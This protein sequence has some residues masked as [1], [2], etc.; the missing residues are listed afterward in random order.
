VGGWVH[1]ASRLKGEQH[2]AQVESV[3]A[4]RKSTTT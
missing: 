1:V 4:C 3:R 2:I